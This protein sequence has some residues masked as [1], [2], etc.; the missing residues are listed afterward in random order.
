MLSIRIGSTFRLVLSISRI[1]YF[2]GVQGRKAAPVILN[3]LLTMLAVIGGWEKKHTKGVSGA[4][5]FPE[6]GVM[7]VFMALDLFL[8]FLF[9]EVRGLRCSC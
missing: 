4:I 7:G 9:W 6:A 3:G 5:T 2:L 1:D 8:F